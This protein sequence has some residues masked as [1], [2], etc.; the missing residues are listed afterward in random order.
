M[1]PA[2]HGNKAEAVHELALAPERFDPFVEGGGNRATLGLFGG[3]VVHLPGG[4]VLLAK[5]VRDHVR[6][7]GDAERLAKVRGLGEQ[8]LR[9]DVVEVA[10]ES[11]RHRVP[12]TGS[13]GAALHNGH[14]WEQRV[15]HHR[16]GTAD[17]SPR[18]AELAADLDSHFLSFND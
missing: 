2:R 4:P 10:L 5:L 11:D 6:L 15:A 18:G 1:K 3:G 17:G 7:D 16:L 9:V 13:I 8:G 14:P 12:A